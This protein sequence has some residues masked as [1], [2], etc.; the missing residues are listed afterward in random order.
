MYKT[1][2]HSMLK[3]TIVFAL[4]KMDELTIDNII[5]RELNANEKVELIMSLSDER[6]KEILSNMGFKKEFLKTI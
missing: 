6:I 1:D 5:S 4:S 2:H 3:I